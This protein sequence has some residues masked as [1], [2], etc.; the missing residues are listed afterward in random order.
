GREGGTEQSAIP[1]VGVKFTAD[2]RHE[3]PDAGVRSSFRDRLDLDAA[4]EAYP[5]E[6]V[7]GEVEDHLILGP[8]LVRFL[9][10]GSLGFG[11]FGILDRARPGPLDRRGTDSAAF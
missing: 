1:Q 6:I 7:A 11:G 5:S 3:M 8:I 4:V 9:K 10:V 2:L